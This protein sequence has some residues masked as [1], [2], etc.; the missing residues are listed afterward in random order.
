MDIFMDIS[1]DI[2]IHGNPAFFGLLRISPTRLPVL[3]PNQNPG[4]APAF[5]SNYL[6][7]VE[8]A[9]EVLFML[10][11]VCLFVRFSSILRESGYRCHHGQWFW[12]HANK[13]RA[14][15]VAKF[16]P[17]GYRRNKCVSNSVMQKELEHV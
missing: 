8:T 11:C 14:K 6:N 17:F 7:P 9:V 1:M 4:S 3:L 2:H 5:T 16:R 10:V 12:N 15:L 13:L